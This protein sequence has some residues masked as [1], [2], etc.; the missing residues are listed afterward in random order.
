MQMTL[1]NPT[2]WYV[3]IVQCSDNTLYTG[4][5]VNIKYRLHQHNM[6][7]SGARYTR[8]RRPVKLVYLET[9]TSRSLATR[10]EYEIKQM[11]V[12]Q[13][14]ALIQHQHRAK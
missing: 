9:S 14:R 8:S 1:D 13:K 2:N 10:R 12:K 6:L 7:K 5:C 4:I 11:N 3:Y